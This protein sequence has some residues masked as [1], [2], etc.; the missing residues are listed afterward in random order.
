MSDV[1]A[2][3][4]NFLNKTTRLIAGGDDDDD[5]DEP[6]SN[7]DLTNPM[8]LTAYS[9][10]TD[11]SITAMQAIGSQEGEGIVAVGGDNAG[12]GVH[13]KGGDNPSLD[14]KRQTGIGVFGETGSPPPKTPSDELT[15]F[16]TLITAS[17]GVRG[18][19][20]RDHGVAGSSFRSDGV[21][22]ASAQQF[23]VFGRGVV[24]VRGD[25]FSLAARGAS[26][27]GVIGTSDG[28]DAL[29]KVSGSNEGVRGY[30]KTGFA[31]RGVSEQNRA[32]VF[33]TRSATAQVRLVPTTIS[34]GDPT[35]NALQLSGL[36]GDLIV[37]KT[38]AGDANLW[39]CF[40]D[41]VHWK[42]VA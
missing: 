19:S 6:S 27:I 30:S 23:G 25:G 21:V 5:N 22:G 40:R 13:G 4:D 3:Q 41:G 17:S 9:P 14:M 34:H 11:K 18:H 24:G 29:T 8:V 1:V 12:I 37:L 7:F 16:S 36:A 42:Q 20:F 2:Q 10:L 15:S 39:F 33:E 32:G 26:Q 28:N 38:S 35:P 31:L